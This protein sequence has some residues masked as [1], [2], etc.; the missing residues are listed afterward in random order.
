MI[1]NDFNPLLFL[2]RMKAISLGLFGIL[3]IPTIGFIYIIYNKLHFTFDITKPFFLLT[4]FLFGTI[5]PSGYL[6]SKIIFRNIDQHDSLR[7]KL[8]KYR[9]GQIFR[10]VTCE[11]IGIM[12]IFSL[13]LTSNLLCLIFLFVVIFLM[14]KYYPTP[15]KIGREIN[16]TQNEINIFYD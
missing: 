8:Q 11:V 6:F 1:E 5:L 4:V 12:I 7:N 13:V 16:L 9:T 10:I 15:D 14:V 3:I 2:A